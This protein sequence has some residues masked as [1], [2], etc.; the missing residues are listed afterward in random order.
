M[1]LDRNVF[2]DRLYK[3]LDTFAFGQ[4][5]EQKFLKYI[6]LSDNNTSASNLMVSV[7]IT[8][9]YEYWYDSYQGQVLGCHPGPS[10]PNLI[11]AIRRENYTYWA[12]IDEGGGSS[13][14]GTGSEGTGGGSTPPM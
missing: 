11:S 10:C 4:N 9:C 6:K 13:G 8:F 5:E 12:F 3:I 1:N 7:T 14:G 2:D